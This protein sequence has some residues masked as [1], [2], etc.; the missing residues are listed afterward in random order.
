[1]IRECFK[2]NTGIRFH[3]S[4]LRNIGLDPESLYPI[5]KERPPALFESPL[6]EPQAG[7]STL[8]PADTRTHGRTETDASAKTLINGKASSS[9]SPPLTEEEE[10]LLDAH[11]T[12][13]DQLIV[14]NK[15]WWILEI[16]P[17]NQRYQRDEDDE[18]VEEPVYAFS[19]CVFARH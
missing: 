18:W 6:L 7:P 13:Y 14:G 3:S 19:S 9:S 4:L 12:L 16:F 5:V 2:T 17:L 15:G 8:S 10:D 1:M 11:S